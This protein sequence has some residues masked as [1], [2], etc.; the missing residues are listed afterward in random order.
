MMMLVA[1]ALD[2]LFGVGV[3]NFAYLSS[4]LL[5]CLYPPLLPA[6]TVV[7]GLIIATYLLIFDGLYYQF[8][9]IQENIEVSR[10]FLLGMQ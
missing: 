3:F 5:H 8:I 1:S 6:V 10:L 4:Y 9:R 2:C 7:T